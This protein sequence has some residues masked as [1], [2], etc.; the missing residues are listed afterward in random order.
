MAKKKSR[1]DGANKSEQKETEA[2]GG[3]VTAP[4]EESAAPVEKSQSV[5]IKIVEVP[6]ELQPLVDRLRGGRCVLCAGSRLGADGNF[7]TLVEKLASQLPDPPEQLADARRVLDKRPLAA[8]G[9][10]RR[11]LGDNF[12]ASLQGAM[13]KNSGELSEAVKIFGELPFRAVVT[14]AYDDTFERAFTRDGAQPRV[15]TPRDSAELKK[16][17]KARFVFKALGD[18]ARADTIVW[19]AEDLQTALADGGYRMVAHD[20]YR[21]RSFLF[22]G[23]D[24]GDPD[25]GILLERVLSGAR[26]GDVE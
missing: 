4:V 9:W 17:G 10:V 1:S 6:P 20:L 18:V 21:S 8:A 5:P 14:T 25:L 24:G 7:R 16:D 12:V 3:E 22:V 11:R 23:F 19:S 13:V 15:Y 26:A 2:A